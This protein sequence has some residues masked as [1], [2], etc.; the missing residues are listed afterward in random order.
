MQRR[1]THLSSRGFLCHDNAQN[2]SHLLLHCKRMISLADFLEHDWTE[3]DHAEF[4]IEVVKC[5]SNVEGK[6]RRKGGIYYRLVYG[7]LCV[8]R[9]IQGVLKTIAALIRELR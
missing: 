2:N 9:E 4:T 3:L 7:G 1:G 5:W 8:K 6:G